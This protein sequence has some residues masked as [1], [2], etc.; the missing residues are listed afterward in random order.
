MIN[1]SRLLTDER[2]YVK[3]AIERKGY[4]TSTIENLIELLVKIKE[5]K[6]SLDSVRRRRNGQQADKSI[7]VEDKR[8][9]RDEISV[10]EKELEILEIA[11]GELLYDIP[12]L[13]DDAAPDGMGEAQNIVIADCDDDYYHCQTENPLT[14]WDIGKKLDILDVEL[15]SKIS[16]SMF[17]LFKGKGS[18]L[19]RALVN[20]CCSLHEDKY[21]DILPPHMVSSSSLT[22]TGHLPKFA[23]DQYKCKDDD[24]WLIPTAEVPLTAAFAN[25]VFQ[26]KE[27]PVRRMGYTVAFRREAGS[28]GKDTRG[29]QR[30][31][32]FHKVELLKI[33]KPEDVESELQDLL[34]DCLSIIRALK[35]RYR[36]VDLCAGD[37][38]DKYARCYDIELYAPGVKRWL[39]ISSIGHFSDYQARRANI[40]YVDVNGKKQVAYTMNGSGMATPRVWATIIETYQQMDGSV[41]VPEV[42]RPFMGCDVIK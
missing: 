42:L 5:K 20:Y 13:P 31:H 16:G 30:V 23:N 8:V 6:T 19:I 11:A 38:G 33:V 18:K 14:H 22:Y 1:T 40:K 29:L 17:G 4:D 12:N 21:L 36:I 9:L 7:S 24:L 27:L 28:A 35:L 15:A 25:T 26:S 39:E 32:E 37:M 2:D 41:I 34:Q 10:Q 3:S